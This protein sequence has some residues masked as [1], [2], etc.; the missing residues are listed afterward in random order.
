MLKIK[1]FTNIEN[2]GAGVMRGN[3]MASIT[4]FVLIICLSVLTIITIVV[5]L[6]WGSHK[7]KSGKNKQS[8]FIAGACYFSLIGIGFML[9]EISLIQR[10]SVYLGHPIYALGILLFSMILSTGL[11]SLLSEKL[12]LSKKSLVYLYPLVAVAVIL[13]LRFALSTIISDT[14]TSHIG[15]KIFVS[16]IIVF[17]VG[18]ILGIY[19]PAGMRLVK[20]RFTQ[21]T[22]WFWALNGIFGVLSSALAIFISI[23]IGISVN[24]YI[25]SVCYALLILTVKNLFEESI[26]VK[27]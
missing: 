1:S 13:I 4:L 24:F 14:I 7:E 17:P 8:G 10:L 26:P 9:I 3:L 5:P 22:P 15:F 12:P 18:L 6:L 23:Y 21:E 27:K 20:N 2:L 11:G 25:A 16:I 19:F